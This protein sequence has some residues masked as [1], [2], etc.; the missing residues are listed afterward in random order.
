M[1]I[2]DEDNGLLITTTDIHLARRIGEALKQRL[3]GDSRLSIQFGRKTVP[4][5]LG[6][7]ILNL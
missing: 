4:A 7:L 2:Q 3:P 1:T 5:A 6:T